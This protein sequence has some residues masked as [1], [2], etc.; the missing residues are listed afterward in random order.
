MDMERAQALVSGAPLSLS[1]HREA[2]AEAHAE[3]PQRATLAD[4]AMQEIE[5]GIAKLRSL[6]H[7]F[8][9]VQGDPPPQDE[10]PKMLY[11]SDAP[12]GLSQHIAADQQEE[13]ELVQQGW[14]TTQQE[15]AELPPQEQVE[16]PPPN[17]P[18]P[19]GLD[20]TS[21]E[22]GVVTADSPNA[23]L[24][25]AGAAGP[26]A[27]SQGEDIVSEQEPEQQDQ[28]QKAQEQV[29]PPNPS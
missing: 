23:G 20:Q 4:L 29:S 27:V 10:F 9:L 12:G 1:E 5:A 14:R 28:M 3:H 16:A 13:D 6:G 2:L 8:V 24:P 19:Q 7:H 22:P 26:G 11:H 17:E 21:S 18:P 25:P 15:D